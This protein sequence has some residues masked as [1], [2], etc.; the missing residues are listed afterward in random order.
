MTTRLLGQYQGLVALF[1]DH[2]PLNP[3]AIAQDGASAVKAHLDNLSKRFGESVRWSDAQFRQ[4][5]QVSMAQQDLKSALQI[6][7]RYIEHY[8]KSPVAFLIKA[9]LLGASGD[10]E[11][12]LQAVNAGIELYE[13]NPESE[14]TEVYSQLRAMKNQLQG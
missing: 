1:E 2:W 12:S 10:A 4:A 14:L 3:S 11:R 6:T 9:S 5:V 7:E 13:A 8:P